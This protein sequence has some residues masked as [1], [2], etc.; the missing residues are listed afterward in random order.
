MEEVSEFRGRY[1]YLCEDSTEGI[2]TAVY[3]AFAE[4]HRKE[5]TALCLK[6]STYT[7]ELFTTYIPVETDMEKAAKV[8]RTMQKKVSWQVYDALQMASLSYI[9]EKQ[10][11]SI[12]LSFLR[13]KWE[14]KCWTT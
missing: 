3:D 10:M 14:I 8:A 6:E 2:F 11:S 12:A 13:C 7:T 9:P 5:D 4:G 1:V